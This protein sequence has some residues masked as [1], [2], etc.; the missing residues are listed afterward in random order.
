ME[1][2]VRVSII[3]NRGGNIFFHVEKVQYGGSD[4]QA[5][6]VDISA[7]CFPSRGQKKHSRIMKL[8][9]NSSSQ[10]FDPVRVVIQENAAKLRM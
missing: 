6:E 10:F 4:S 9:A 8:R 2:T 7:K 3:A 5:D 1:S